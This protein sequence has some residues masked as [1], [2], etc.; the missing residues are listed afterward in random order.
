MASVALAREN[1][2]TDWKNMPSP[3]SDKKTKTPVG[4]SAD[5]N[6]S[7]YPDQPPPYSSTPSSSHT[8]QAESPR[9][10]EPIRPSER[11]NSSAGAFN[12]PFF[13]GVSITNTGNVT[14]TDASGRST[15]IAGFGAGP[16]SGG[17]SFSYTQVGSATFMSATYMQT[18]SFS[19]P[20]NG[21]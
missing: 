15:V 3:L 10:E 16:R 4:G 2:T 21:D 20:R 18:E 5:P 13:Q 8:S 6:Q 11:P 19:I 7:Q 14:V 1:D 17:S 12:I 9:L